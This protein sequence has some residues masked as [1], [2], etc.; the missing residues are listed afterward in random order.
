MLNALYRDIIVYHIEPLE[1]REI[2]MKGKG[3]QQLN[4][5]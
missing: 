1:D 2:F 5:K 4:D 3:A